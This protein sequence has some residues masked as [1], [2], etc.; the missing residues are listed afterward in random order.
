MTE[1][2]YDEKLL[3]RRCPECHQADMVY[4]GDG[5]ANVEDGDN[6]DAEYWK[7]PHC[8]ETILW[9]IWRGLFRVEEARKS[10]APHT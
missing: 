4:V 5:V 6:D 8:G 7:C 3:N 1:Q 2:A 10:D 9:E